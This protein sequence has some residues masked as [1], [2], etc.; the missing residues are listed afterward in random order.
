MIQIEEDVVPAGAREIVDH[1][2]ARA[3]S[4][5]GLSEEQCALLSTPFREVKVAVP[6]RMDNGSTEIFAGY[7]IQHNGARGPMKGG[8]RYHPSVDDDEIHALAEVM[9]WKTALAGVPFGGA[10]GGI[11]C[12]PHRLSPGEIE[13]L[14]RKFVSRIHRVLGPYRDIPAPDINTNS[15]VMAWILDEYSSRNGYSPACVTGKPV[16]LGGLAGRERATGRGVA[17]VIGKYIEAHQWPLAGLKVAIQGFGNVGSSAALALAERG[18]DVFAVTDEFGGAVR[19]DRS[20]L[21]IDQMINH[22]RQTGSVIGFPGA[23]QISNAELLT[24]DCDVL[25]PAAVGGVLHSGNAN[26]VRARLIAEAANLPTTPE[27]DEILERQ[28]ITVLPDILTNAGGV[29]ASYFEWMQNL[30]QTSWDEFEVNRQLGGYLGRAY[31]DIA[32]LAGREN[33]S[34]R[35]AAYRIAIDRVAKA[36]S[37]RGN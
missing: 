31:H 23:E 13:R 2:F 32:A 6:V 20:G 15:R 36:E 10:K 7:R 14:T 1:H 3:A 21:P 29:V 37:L 24:A 25:I 28:G 8:I 18:C 27:A 12:D 11:R 33:V 17:F 9:T 34:L 26:G 35:R 16:E 30:Q 5:L 19:P 4:D 22:V